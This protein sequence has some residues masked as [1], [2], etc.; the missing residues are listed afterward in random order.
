M[1]ADILVEVRDLTRRFGSFVAVDHVSFDLPRGIVFG[2]LGPNGAG[3]STTIR[4]LAGLLAPT[5]GTVRGLGGLDVARD[6]EAWKRR[7]GYMSQRFSLYTDLTVVENL[8]F[9]GRIYG[10][11]ADRLTTRMADLTRRLHLD[12]VRDTLTAT[13]ST[14]QRQRVAL[15]RALVRRP[16]VL[17]LDDTTSALDP[18]TEATVLANLRTSLGGT[19]VLLVASRPSTIGLADQV[20]HLDGGRL[21]AA[22]THEELMGLS[23]GYRDLVEAFETDRRDRPTERSGAVPATDRGEV[24][25]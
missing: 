1:A 4:M 21:V 12:P 3:K 15:A 6:T 23:P 7:L 8:R 11:G 18:G 19:T 20:A 13:L 17:V 10:L 24:A 2:V 25:R 16:T 22:G 5:G 14:G 9:F